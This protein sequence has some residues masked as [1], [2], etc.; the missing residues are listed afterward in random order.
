[1]STSLYSILT[2]IVW[3]CI[4]VNVYYK[5]TETG[6]L[7]DYSSIPYIWHL[8]TLHNQKLG[9]FQHTSL[10]RTLAITD[11]KWKSRVLTI[12]IYIISQI[13]LAFW[14]VLTYDLLEDRRIDDVIITNIFPLCFKMAESFENLDNILPDWAKENIEKSLVEAVNRYEK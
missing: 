6:N 2:Y 12:Y 3:L 8:A 14:L 1:M 7:K 13:I 4:K 5:L 10:L 11:T 9:H